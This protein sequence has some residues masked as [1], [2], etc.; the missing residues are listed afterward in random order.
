MANRGRPTKYNKKLADKICQRICNGESLKR[1][2]ESKDIPSRNQ[3]HMWLLQEDKKDFYYNYERSI[4]VRAENMF[5]ELTEIA[6][7]GS[8]DYMERVNQDGTP[9]EVLRPEHIQRSRLRTDVRKWYL[10][11]IMP[12]KFGDKLDMTS[13]G[14]A[15]KSN[16][17]VVQRFS[18][19]DEDKK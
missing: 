6:D 14:E 1:I 19:D 3:V 10:S 8:N 16:V 15:I 4:N 12:K 17:I 9:S 2:C 18:E 13:G 5:D 7:D 11:K